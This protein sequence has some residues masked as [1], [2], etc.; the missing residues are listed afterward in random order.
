MEEKE[1]TEK[2]ILSNQLSLKPL[3]TLP[4]FKMNISAQFFLYK[5]LVLS[6][7]QLKLTTTF[8]KDSVAVY[9]PKTSLML[10][11]GSDL[12]AQIVESL[13]S[14]LGHQELKS[15]ELSEDRNTL[16]EGESQ[17]LIVGSSI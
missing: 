3:K 14:T 9:L 8:P 5:N 13:M 6:K 11:N 4:S 1:L 10:L 16:E 7:K 2:D 15:V 17:D 12:L